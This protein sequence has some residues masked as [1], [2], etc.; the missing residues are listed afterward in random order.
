MKALLVGV[1]LDNVSSSVFEK[2]MQELASLT[3]ACNIEVSDT[4]T[5]ELPEFNAK[6]Y[7]GKGKVQEIKEFSEA[8]ECDVV[9]FNDELTP[10]QISNLDSA[11]EKTIYDRTYLILEIFKSRAKTREAILQVELASLSYMLPR[12][13]G[14]RSGLSRQRGAG[15]GY[16][17]GRGAGETQLELD[18]RITND[19][20]AQIKKELRDLTGKRKQQ[21]IKR[22]KS[23]LRTVALVGYTN[24]GKSSLMNAFLNISPTSEK[25][26][27][28]KDML[29]ATLE[30][31]TRKIDT[32]YGSFLLTDTVG[33]IDK[34][35]HMLVEAFKS[36]LEEI[37]EADL[38]IH[39]VDASNEKFLDQINTTNKVLDEIGV[40]QIPIVYAF[41]KID[42]IDEYLYIP[43]EYPDAIRI[44]AKKDIN[45]NV[46]IEKVINE[47]Y[48]DYSSYTFTIPYAKQSDL[49]KIKEYAVNSVIN[50]EDDTVVLSCLAPSFIGEKFSEYIK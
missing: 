9:I 7:V 30:T 28:E 41:N 11:I 35:P 13:T 46:L 22:N 27:M 2:E 4:V 37:K 50:Y 44:S 19:K 47:L 6:T 5:Q 48:R 1:K 33:F 25:V 24:S 12:L 14:L 39:V 32:M 21:R 49:Y 15:G 40:E 10:V 43:K 45:I 20:I 17:H 26:V 23:I 8:L 29:F 16:A 42:K 31:S 36:T 38:L 3:Q 34:L 18:R